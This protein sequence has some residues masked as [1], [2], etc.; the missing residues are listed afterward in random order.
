M[1]FDAE[2]EEDEEKLRRGEKDEDDDDDAQRDWDRVLPVEGFVV[3][4]KA[5][6]RSR[7]ITAEDEAPFD[8]PLP[9]EADESVLPALS[10]KHNCQF[11]SINLRHVAAFHLV[12]SNTSSSLLDESLNGKSRNMLERLSM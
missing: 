11:W 3:L 2:S 6:A 10:A 5:F 12:Q 4:E 7:D 9:L 1:A 8:E